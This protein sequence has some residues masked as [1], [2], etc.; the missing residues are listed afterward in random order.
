MILYGKELDA[1]LEKRKAEK[2]ERR[3]QR[4]TLRNAAR[5]KGV[6]VSELLAYENGYDVCPH[7]EWKD[8]VG[9]FPI[10]KLIFKTCKKCG[11]IN[12]KIV[13]KVN[14]SNLKRVYNVYK[15]IYGK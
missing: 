7:E 10:P 4:I 2:E 15:E 8:S 13:E 11:K 12:E 9:G 5:Q 1:E 3:K 14:D 6:D